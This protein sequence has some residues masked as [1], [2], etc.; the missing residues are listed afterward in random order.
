[1]TKRI[2]T[3]IAMQNLVLPNV[4]L[5]APIEDCSNRNDPP[6][7]CP[8]GSRVRLISKRLTHELQKGLLGLLCS[9]AV[10][11]YHITSLSQLKI[12]TE[13]CER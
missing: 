6:M 12:G 9:A 3:G 13:Y 2:G 4:C 5:F 7:G 1:M 11:G 8:D 10:Q